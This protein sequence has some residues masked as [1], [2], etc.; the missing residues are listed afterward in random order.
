MGAVLGRALGAGA[1]ATIR[2]WGLGQGAGK[3]SRNIFKM[4]RTRFPH[5]R[6][7]RHQGGHPGF[8]IQQLEGGSCYLANGKDKGDSG[9]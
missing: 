4:E 6:G 7:E 8:W 1:V 9:F 3:N 2:W 5:R